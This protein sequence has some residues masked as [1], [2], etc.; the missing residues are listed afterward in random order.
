[1]SEMDFETQMRSIAQRINYPHTP[2]IAGRVM[3]RLRRFP[4][5]TG[6]GVRGEGRSRFI[7][8]GWAWSLTLIVVLLFSLMLIPPVRAAVL[9]FI[10][11]GIV[12]IFPRPT[13]TPPLETPRT[14]TPQSFAPVTATPYLESSTLLVDLSRLAGEKTLPQAQSLVS[15][16]YPILLPTYPRDVGEPDRVFVQDA[17]GAMTILV[18]FDPNDPEKVMLS[19]HIIPEGSWAIRKSEPVTIEETLV[20][21][22]RA[23]WAVGPY[24]LRY[25]NG[26]IDFTRLIDGHVLI[27]TDGNVTYRLESN[28]SME[29]AIKVAESLQ[30]L[31]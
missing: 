12:R 19:L 31:P 27:W 14:A 22:Q 18:W 13:D 4:S 23:V 5:P 6:R 16:Y 25:S 9:E 29:E 21:G 24:P 28:L 7:S 11:I 20:N 8:K 17:D 30:S 15:S 10:Q 3:S 26:D 2:D 1:M